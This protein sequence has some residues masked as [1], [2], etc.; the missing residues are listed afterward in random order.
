[1]MMMMMMILK[2]RMRMRITQVNESM[3]LQLFSEKIR[4]G[5]LSF[6]AFAV[7]A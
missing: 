7:A 5:S 6:E 2:M 3:G 4:G 1:M